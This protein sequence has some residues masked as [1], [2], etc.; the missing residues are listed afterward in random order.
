MLKWRFSFSTVAAEE[1]A[2]RALGHASETSKPVMN[3]TLVLT[4]DWLVC[5]D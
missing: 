3:Q 1:P 4:F 2:Y 5:L